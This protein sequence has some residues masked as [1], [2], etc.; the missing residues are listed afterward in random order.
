MKEISSFLDKVKAWTNHQ[1]DILGISYVGSWARGEAKPTSDLD[2]M[3][4]TTTPQKYLE[5]N[6]WISN[7]GIVK[8]SKREDWGLVQSWRV[9]FENNDEI[10]FGIT[11]KE[12]TQLP[13]DPG[14][15]QVVSDGMK[16]VFDPQDLL[17]Q[18]D[19]AVRTKRS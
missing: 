3:I 14:T 1:D 18:L 9:F 4:I 7:F 13:P 6:E 5:N 2:L 10:E 19:A 8:E 16:I 15:A 17:A 11:T 12:W